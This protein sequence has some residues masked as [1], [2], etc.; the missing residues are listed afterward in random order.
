MKVDIQKIKNGLLHFKRVVTNSSIPPHR[1]QRQPSEVVSMENPLGSPVIPQARANG[2]QPLPN[3]NLKRELP[4]VQANVNRQGGHHYGYLP[5]S[6]FYTANIGRQGGHHYGYLQPNVANRSP[7]GDMPP[8][9]PSHYG[10]MPPVN[11]VVN[12]APPPCALTGL[13]QSSLGGSKMDRALNQ[14][15]SDVVA[16]TVANNNN[17]SAVMSGP[18]AVQQDLQLYEDFLALEALRS[19]VPESQEGLK[20]LGTGDYAL[21]RATDWHKS[22]YLMELLIAYY[23]RHH[24]EPG[25][26][27]TFS[28]FVTTLSAS[29]LAEIWRTPNDTY[30]HEFIRRF[31]QGVRYLSPEKAEKY[32]VAV[33]GA[34]LYWAKW[35]DTTPLDTTIPAFFKRKHDTT[36]LNPDE[37]AIWILSKEDRLYTHP[38]KLHR[39]HHSSFTSGDLIRCGGD[40]EV[41]DGKLIWIS[42]KSGHYMPGFEHLQNAVKIFA[43]K[44]GINAN[45]F[46]VKVFGLE[47]GKKTE[48]LL[49]ASQMLYDMEKVRNDY[50]LY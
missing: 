17:S 28:Q 46:K 11:E 2:N 50:L 25:D 30:T 18:L 14:A 44:F 29:N 6:A 19:P 15:F 8:L 36:R 21:E 5:P 33:R 26:D 43:N 48:V 40:W 47:H 41:K 32:N 3:S 45:A 4:A 20:N 34:N 49:P 23:R 10:R 16:S 7:Y 9:I 12:A 24:F 39:F 35:D 31:I 13:S 1:V 27:V 37:I 42:A 38:A 22:A